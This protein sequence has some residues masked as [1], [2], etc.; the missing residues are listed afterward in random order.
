MILLLFLLFVLSNLLLFVFIVLVLLYFRS[1]HN[2]N[3]F[4]R[5]MFILEKKKELEKQKIKT[6][7][8]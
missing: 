4:L 6:A 7:L 1:L 2:Q 3:G 8:Q 5:V